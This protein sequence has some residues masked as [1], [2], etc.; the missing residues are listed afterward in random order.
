MRSLHFACHLEGNTLT[1]SL[2]GIWIGDFTAE[3]NN[4]Q[5][6]NDDNVHGT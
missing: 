5:S 4:H 6:Y 1:H 2:Q 3:K